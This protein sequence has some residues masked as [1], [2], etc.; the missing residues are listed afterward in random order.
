MYKEMNVCHI[1]TSKKP[2][3]TSV[4]GSLDSG[5]I[6]VAKDLTMKLFLDPTYLWSS[7][8]S[9]HGVEA[10]VGSENEEDNYG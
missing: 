8:Y 4:W 2:N 6:C 3:P 5:G 10:N 1:G 9:C 7:V